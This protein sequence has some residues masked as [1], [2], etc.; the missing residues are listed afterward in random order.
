[1]PPH[2]QASS[3]VVARSSDEGK[4]PLGEAALRISEIELVKAVNI[5]RVKEA[6]VRWVLLHRTIGCTASEKQH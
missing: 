4:C 5:W 3:L 1:M 6:P 2:N